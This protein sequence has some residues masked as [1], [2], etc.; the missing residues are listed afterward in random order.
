MKYHYV[1]KITNIINNKIYV[2]IHYGELN[3]LYYGSGKSIIKAV[4]KYG[5][6]NF[7][8]EILVIGEDREY[9]ADIES[10]IVTKEFIN[11]KDTYNIVVGG[12]MPPIHYGEDNPS[13]RLEVRKQISEKRTG[14]DPNEIIRK[15]MSNGQIGRKHS[16]EMIDN[17]RR[18]VLGS[19]NVAAIKVVQLNKDTKEFIKLYH[20]IADAN[21]E[22]NISNGK[23]SDVCKGKRK[24]TGGYIFMYYD[25]YLK[26]IS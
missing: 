18:K 9:V 21:R 17:Q 25:K 3:D 26:I 11:R 20:C 16:Q 15:N 23:I 12:G 22:L 10:K 19:K 24:T 14:W 7:T 5:R 1:Y 4:K 2:G 6:E 13:K 8:K